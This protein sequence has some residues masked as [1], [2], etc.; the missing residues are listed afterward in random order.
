MLRTLSNNSYSAI[1]YGDVAGD[2]GRSETLTKVVGEASPNRHVSS[3]YTQH[4]RGIVAMMQKRLGVTLK[5]TSITSITS[6]RSSVAMGSQ[7]TFSTLFQRCLL[8][9]M[10]WRPGTTSNQR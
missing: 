5:I 2:N 8:I 7:K 3:L 9:D 10:T 4:K 6:R 1:Y